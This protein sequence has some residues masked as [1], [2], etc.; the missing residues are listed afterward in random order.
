MSYWARTVV[1]PLL[2]L[3]ALRPLA[4]NKRGIKVDELYSGNP[5]GLTSQAAHVHRVWKTGFEVLDWGLKRFENHWPKKMRRRAIDLCAAWVTERL[6]GEDGLGAIYPAMANSVMMYDVL[7]Y[8]EDH[9]HR[10]IARHSVEKLLVIK[11]DEAYCQPCVSP[12]WDTALAAHAMLE[13]GTPKA[14]E[15]AHAALD[16]LG[17]RQILDTV[18]DWAEQ[19]PDVRPGGWAFQYG[20]DYYPDL[21]DTA[22]VVMAMDR[23]A[24][25]RGGKDAQAIARGAE[26]TLGLQSHDG[27]FGAFDADNDKFYLNNL[28][29]ADHG[30]LLDPPTAD[31]S[32]RGLD[33]GAD[34]RA[35]QPAHEGRAGWLEKEQEP[36]GSWF[37]RWGVNYIYGTWSVLCAL[38]RAELDADHP[39]VARAV[40]WLKSV[41][42][43]DGG[44]GE[45]CD[46]YALDRKGHEF[47]A[48]T[49]SQT[50]WAL[51]GL[52]AV[53]EARSPEV[54]R[55]VEWL[56]AN[57]A[58]D[59]LWG[60]EVYTG[61][62][63]PRVFYLR[64]HGYPRYFPLWALAR[65]RNLSDSNSERTAWGCK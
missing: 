56:L 62:G 26:W 60:Q 28:P 35:G 42:N 54:A 33:A 59:G 11:D 50:A 36:E 5:A 49:A 14:V 10:A 45:S 3:C 31:V 18:G 63:F 16:W 65:Y 39:M 53:G 12:V 2:V 47:A 25:V 38:G 23:A 32:A 9:P 41:Q 29:F 15:Q 27:G 24:G 7:G 57:Q 8:A 22:V 44:W 58:E 55:G 1:V 40:N 30:A 64:Y 4:K 6:N 21:D 17:E 48:S 51:L 43:E 19:R 52:M 34:G 13:V 37:G 61:G 46:S 20:N